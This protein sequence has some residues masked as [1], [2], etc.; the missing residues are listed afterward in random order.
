MIYIALFPP[1]ESSLQRDPPP[2]HVD[3]YL[4][5]LKLKKEGPSF[6][7]LVVLHFSEESEKNGRSVQ[8]REKKGFIEKKAISEGWVRSGSIMYFLIQN[9][10]FIWLNKND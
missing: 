7:L 5:E 8:F 3:S 10:D 1:R 6:E 9:V 2:Y 4:L